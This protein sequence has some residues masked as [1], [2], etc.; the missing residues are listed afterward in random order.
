MVF[1]TKFASFT[2]FLGT[3]ILF[4]KK[5][6]HYFSVTIVIKIHAKKLIQSDEP[7]LRKMFSGQIDRQTGKQKSPIS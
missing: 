4:S 6:L 1:L 7:L 3:V 5:W 2:Q